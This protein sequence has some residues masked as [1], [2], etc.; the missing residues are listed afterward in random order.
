MYVVG[1][2]QTNSGCSLR[3]ESQFSPAVCVP[4]WQEGDTGLRNVVCGVL[5]LLETG[6]SGSWEMGVHSI[7]LVPSLCFQM[8]FLKGRVAG[9][10]QLSHK[11]VEFTSGG[12]GHRSW[13]RLLGLPSRPGPDGRAMNEPREPFT[14]SSKALH[15]V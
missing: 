13:H 14:H 3:C 12:K 9:K 11:V 15:T 6:S 2:F 1:S 8:C 5:S 4:P 10:H 7:K